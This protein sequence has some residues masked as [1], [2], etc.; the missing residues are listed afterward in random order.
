MITPALARIA[1]LD[2]ARALDVAW[3]AVHGLHHQQLTAGLVGGPDEADALAGGRV[4]ASSRARR[5]RGSSAAGRSRADLELGQTGSRAGR[6]PRSPTARSASS[7]SSSFAW[8]SPPRR[9]DEHHRRRQDPRHLGRVVQRAARRARPAPRRSP[10]AG[11]ARG[12]A[13]ARRRR[14]RLDPP[15]LLLGELAAAGLGGIGGARGPRRASRSSAAASG[16][17][18]S[19]DQLAPPGDRGRDAGLQAEHAGG[20]DAAALAGD[21]L[22]PRAPRRRRRG[23]RP[24][25]SPSAWCRRATPG[26]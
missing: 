15:D 19:A 23:R 18:R 14:D 4:R 9:G 8:L 3:G 22:D 25:A 24:G 16:W 12:G 1:G 20:G 7:V 26:P 2:V 21:P 13:P 5:P 6:M 11:L 10:R 17:R